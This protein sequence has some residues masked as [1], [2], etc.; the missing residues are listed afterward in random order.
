[1]DDIKLPDDMRYELPP[2]A[3][4]YMLKYGLSQ[5][6][7][8]LSRFGW[9]QSLDRM[10][11]PVYKDDELVYWQGRNLGDVTPD[12]PKYKNVYLS[13]SRDI[14]A[15]FDRR[16][17]NNDL[18]NTLVLVEAIISAVKLSRHVDT[19]A[20]L[21]SFVPDS[22]IDYMRE[23]ERIL[24]WLDPDKLTVSIT[25]AMRFH[26]LTGRKIMPIFSD[27]KPKQYSDKEILC[28]IQ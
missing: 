20:L 26:L 27:K 23:Y 21:G 16:D 24:V 14:Y 15:K 11:M 10:I 2:I 18:G 22:I 6:E 28:Q 1:M 17:E 25:E 4:R 9:S 5:D 7:V 13:G 3:Q 8:K 12:N 19:V